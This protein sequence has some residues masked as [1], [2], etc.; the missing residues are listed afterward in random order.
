M[1]ETANKEECAGKISLKP[2]E[3]PFILINGL[4]PKVQGP[5]EKVKNEAEQNLTPEEAH[6]NEVCF[7]VC[8]RCPI[9]S[10]QGGERAER[11][12]LQMR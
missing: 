12:H 9:G 10:C 8:R 1:R 7:Y 2:E 6:V 4:S 11:P 3:A 5:V